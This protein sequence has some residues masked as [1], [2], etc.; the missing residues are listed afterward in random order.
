M[1]EEIIDSRFLQTCDISLEEFTLQPCT[2]VI[3]GG[4]GDL[5]RKK[6]L[7]SVFHLFKERELTDGFSLL[8]FGRK[9]LT[10]EQYRAMMEE[11][12]KSFGEGLYDEGTWREFDK[13]VFSLSGTFE[14][15][16][17]YKRLRD[18]IEGITTPDGGGNKNVIYYL[19]VPPQVTP[20]LVKK[21]KYHN[22]CR[23]PFNTKIIVEKPFG[24]DLSS[25]R[26]LNRILTGAF[27]EEQVYRIDHY[28]GKEPVQ[29]IIFFRFS[30]MIFEQIWN[31]LFVDNVQITV[32]ESIG[33]EGRGGFYEQTGVVRDIV[34]NHM[35]QILG[36]IAME[37]PVGFR[38]DFIRD[39]KVKI[40]RSMRPMSPD[41]I[42]R[43]VVRGQ[44]GRG[45]QNGAAVPAYGEEEGVGPASLVP[46]FFA[47][48]F[49]ID[50]LRWAGVPF[51]LR[52]G[53]RMKKRVTEICI[54]L[55]RLPLQLFGRT[56]D[57]MEPNVLVLTIQPDEKISMRFMVKYPY[58]SNQIY[59][60]KMVFSYREAFKT[61]E[62]PAYE[63]L[64]VDCMKGD[65]T[66]F[67]RQDE[68][69][70]MWEIV[71][72]IIRRWEEVTPENFPNYAAGTWGP[73]EAHLLLEQEDR[74]WITD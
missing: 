53:K 59:S 18:K 26:E 65:L 27:R 52:T 12:V 11:E 35:L 7:P 17:S 9:E 29:N 50:N 5:S 73:P 66:P 28:L 21:L 4:A 14:D 67:V 57:S 54:Q 8:G 38:A 58:V 64:L 32:A 3:F 1:S 48:K 70:L 55:K 72:P 6:L 39:E 49:Y 16:E 30:N 23:G 13:H 69:E 34:Q 71:D 61:P 33:I 2:M 10:D 68:V 22:L 24:S 42:D 46:T 20:V 36:F 63:Q 15:D 25:A 51:Y 40:L 31:R 43:F 74:C 56:C 41:Y 60:T 62:H 45:K 44:Y 37:P 47:G 19:A